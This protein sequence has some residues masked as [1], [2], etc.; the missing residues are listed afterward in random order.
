MHEILANPMWS[1]L[2]T[3]H[4]GFV[5]TSGPLKRFSPEVAPFCA[6]EHAGAELGAPDCMHTGEAVYFLG[7]VPA[8]PPV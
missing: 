1:S 8:L 3:P 6:V 5:R 4:A 2:T 7:T